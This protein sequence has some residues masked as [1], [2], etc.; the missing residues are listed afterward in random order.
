MSQPMQGLQQEPNQGIQ[1]QSVGPQ[2]AGISD[3]V[4]QSFANMV[5]MLNSAP[6]QEQALQTF[7][8]VNPQFKQVMEMCNGRDPKEVFMS[9]CQKRGVN[10]QH[11]FQAFHKFGVF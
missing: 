8:Q 11:V 2:Q 1:M 7:A 4:M 6:N 10:P 5:K 3:Q 9:E